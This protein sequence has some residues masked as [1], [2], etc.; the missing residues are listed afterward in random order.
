MIRFSAKLSA[1]R[2]R[3]LTLFVA[4]A[5][6]TLTAA[7][8]SADLIVTAQNVSVSPGS[9]NNTLEI[10]LTNTGGTAV[11]I[12][13][14]SFGLSVTNT[15]I[16]FTSADIST[17]SSYIFLGHSLFGPIISTTPPPNGQVVIASDNYDVNNSGIMLASGATVG[18]G[19]VLFDVS[20][21][22]AGG[23]F[24]VSLTNFPATSLSDFGGNDVPI[25]A[26]RDGSI[27]IAGVPE[28]T[29][30]TLFG[31]GILAVAA[32]WNRKGR[33]RS[34]RRGVVKAN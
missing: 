11:A 24:P 25:T 14:F 19:R 7:T 9:T 13:G 31:V 2:R 29:S 21:V 3:W 28:P 12:G 22:A 27:T 16:T 34:Y 26:L 20:S 17:A 6:A 1:F 10:D 18:L 5:A 8:G 30:L 15:D 32:R 33:L 23:A 4:A